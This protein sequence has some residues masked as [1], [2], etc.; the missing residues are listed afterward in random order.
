MSEWT[1]LDITTRRLHRGMVKAAITKLVERL[2]ELER[3]LSSHTDRL[4][5]QCLQQ[6]LTSLDGEFK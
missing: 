4:A 3:K 2:L 6:K 1:D 5:A